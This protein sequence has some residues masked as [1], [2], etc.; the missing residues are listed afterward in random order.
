MTR[1]LLRS[2]L[3]AALALG[4]SVP[5][6]AAC[7]YTALTSG[8][9]LPV[10]TAPTP[11]V[12]TQ[13]TNYWSAIAVRPQPADD[14]DVGVYSAT[15]AEPACVSGMLANSAW[16]A[17]VLDFV[18]GDFNRNAAGTYYAYVNR[19]S[20]T[21]NGSMEW[22]G[23]AELVAANGASVVGAMASNELIRVWDVALSA[24]TTYAF[25]FFPQTGSGAHLS[26]YGN[27]GG[28]TY[29][30]GRSGAVF[31]V[32]GS[33]TFTPTTSGY[34]G[35]VVTN[36]AGV[37][38]TYTLAITT[39][40]CP[41]P[42]T[43]LAQS[44]VAV[45][46]PGAPMAFE[47]SAATWMGCAVRGRT[48]DWD[49]GL[50]GQ[51][52]GGPAPHC[53]AGILATSSVS[54]TLAD[55]VV[56]DFRPW[57]TGWYFVS[58]TMYT[59]GDAGV[60]EFTGPPAALSPN[61]DPSS[62]SMAAD[63]V[64]DM[65]HVPLQAGHTYTLNFTPPAPGMTLLLFANTGGG[66]YFAGRNDAVVSTTTSTTYTAPVTGVYGIAVMNDG[67]I[68]GT[69]SVGVG[70][71]SVVSAL[72]PNVVPAWTLEPYAYYSF[73][74]ALGYWT[75]IGVRNT[76]YDWDL[77]VSSNHT[78][79]PWPACATSLVASSNCVP[80]RQDLIVGDFN[81][82]T[83]GTYYVRA[84]QQSP[85][86]L[87]APTVQWDSGADR[88]LPNDNNLAT[89][90]TGPDD[91]V[92]CWDVYLAGGRTYA[93]ELSHS[94]GADLKL[95]LFRNSNGVVCW[96][97]RDGAEFEVSATRTY[98]APTPGYYGVVVVNDNGAPDA[99]SISV[100]TC[101][102]VVALT[103][104]PATYVS[105]D[106]VAFLSFTQAMPYWTP[107]ATRGSLPAEDF[108]LEVFSSATGGSPGICAGGQ[109]AGSY[110][111]VGTTDFVVGD[112]GFNPF[113]TYYADVRRYMGTGTSVSQYFPGSQL[114]FVGGPYQARTATSSFLVESW[115]ALLT[116][117]QQYTVKFTHGPGLDAKVDVFAPSGG[118]Y[119]TNRVNA[120]VE[121]AHTVTFTATVSGWYG[122]VVVNDGGA[123]PFEIGIYSGTTAVDN[124]PRPERD[125]L[126]AISP[127]PGRAGLRLDYALR[128]SGQPAFEF[129]DMAGRV[130]SR[131]EPGAKE[132][133]LWTAAWPATDKAGRP[134]R[135]G[136]Y[137]V[138][139]RVGDHT[140]GTRKLTLLD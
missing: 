25:D 53:L 122:V 134:L 75:A 138:R 139:M 45:P 22:V 41:V 130:V 33:A 112:F 13:T 117:G 115:D 2:A 50:Y 76:T 97:G 17:G 108:D 137:F 129:L 58:P 72:T 78:A 12:F 120:L 110:A 48:G 65:Y 23:S 118:V 57:T 27:A 1:R 100:K 126:R 11:C 86:Y 14:W 92:G 109:L 79:M 63:D 34:Y 59:G 83:A 51:P 132:A 123:G 85:G 116:A 52:G 4:A 82:N 127:N 131:F 31:D 74:Q 133:G 39:S 18:I 46:S 9:P 15:G 29:W 67:A 40:A 5:A 87:S 36:D 135:A 94:G 66:A 88:I 38:F 62:A 121:S 28:G 70:D 19:Y 20:G 119:W 44:P 42:A 56:G 111:N 69:Y 10:A 96:A 24:G 61:S 93:F 16:G 6:G 26:L 89:R 106:P 77:T 105:P 125:A 107:I 128:E 124:L 98:L 80:P 54:S 81:Y 103:P 32:T 91:V 55:I 140:I 21:G 71:C 60:V 3:A 136:L 8:V 90:T 43:L 104:A 49:I 37:N 84:H 73:T 99:Y 114:L 30:T 7:V 35:V 102:P 101:N 113:G 68:A 64:A 95:L 47:A